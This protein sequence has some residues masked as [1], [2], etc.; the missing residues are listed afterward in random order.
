MELL[1]LKRQIHK[2]IDLEDDIDRLEDCYRWLSS[3]NHPILSDED[4]KELLDMAENPQNY[5]WTSHEDVKA[6]IE[7]WRKK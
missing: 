5:N 1:E 7:Q 6:Q 2:E 4:K 3:S